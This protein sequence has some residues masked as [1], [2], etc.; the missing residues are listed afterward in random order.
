M[1]EQ[2]LFDKVLSPGPVNA[3]PHLCLKARHGNSGCRACAEVCPSDAIILNPSPQIDSSKC[4][5][6]GACVNIC[7]TEAFSLTDLTYEALL[8]Q[9]EGS[10]SKELACSQ[11]A[12]TE[13]AVAIPC[14]GY[15][16]ESFLITAAL[17]DDRPLVINTSDCRKCDFRSGVKAGIKSLKRARQLLSVCGKDSKIVISHQKADGLRVLNR[18]RDFSRREFFSHLGIGMRKRVGDAVES[19]GDSASRTKV[20]LEP[21]TPKKRIRLLEQTTKLGQTASGQIRANNLPF[22][23]VE[24]NHD[25]TACGMCVTF[26][27]TGALTVEKSQ[28]SQIINFDIQKCLGCDL[29]RDICPEKAVSFSSEINGSELFK[30]K[31]KALIE[32]EEQLCIFCG[33]S[34]ISPGPDN[35]CFVCEKNKSL[36]EA[37][38]GAWR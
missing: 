3:A 8:G 34:F 36:E 29:C 20:S 6:C 5:G 18:S 13:N 4:G 17:L 1:S 30:G 23:M 7:P 37:L 26:C 21:R 11:L 2:S 9:L 28:G 16:D 19:A 24:I 27:P 31:K 14:A 10:Q 33:N 32:H 38:P 25:C 35:L 15:L 12:E 22:S